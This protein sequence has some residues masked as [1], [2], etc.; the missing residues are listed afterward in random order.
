MLYI[1]LQVYLPFYIY[2]YRFTYHSIYIVTGLLTILYILLQVY[3]PCYGILQNVTKEDT[4]IVFSNIESI[5][6]LSR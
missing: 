5:L 3:L 1:L 4:S 2:C 6:T